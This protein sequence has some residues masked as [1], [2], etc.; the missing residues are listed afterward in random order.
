MSS[1]NFLLVTLIAMFC[2]LASILGA[3]IL[4]RRR[5]RRI[6]SLDW[7]AAKSPG[8]FAA[9]C[10][11]FLRDAGWRVTIIKADI[12]QVRRPGRYQPFFVFCRGGGLRTPLSFIRD[13]ESDIAKGR[14]AGIVVITDVNPPAD[15]LEKADVIG[16]PMLT[17][18]ELGAFGDAVIRM[19]RVEQRNVIG[20][21]IERPVQ[22]KA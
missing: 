7:P 12:L 22:S 9:Y 1:A 6:L 11:T 21:K 3:T 18:R 14:Y 13:C 15:V 16:V 19:R 5:R 2:V 17:V 10:T 4:V 8:R 20:G